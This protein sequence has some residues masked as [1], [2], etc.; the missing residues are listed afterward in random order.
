MKTMRSFVLVTAALLGWLVAPALAADELEMQASLVDA[1]KN[2]AK[3]NAEV[4]VDVKGA[5][6]IDPALAKPGATPV[7]A[8]LHYRVDDGPVIATPVQKLSFHELSSGRHR[9][10]VVLADPEHKPLGPSETLEV[11]IPARLVGRQQ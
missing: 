9:I 6:L 8:H 11:T 3:G 1:E 5:E 4:R 2:A 10:E 7:Q